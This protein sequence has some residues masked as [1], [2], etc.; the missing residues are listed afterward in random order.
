MNLARNDYWTMDLDDSGTTVDLTWTAATAGMTAD[1]FKE[2][3]ATFAGLAE[4]RDTPGLLVDVRQFGFQMTPDLGEWRVTDIVPRYNAAGVK[5]F[6]Y[7]FP[8]GAETPPESQYPGEDF[9]TG[10]FTSTGDA[11]AWLAG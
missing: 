4:E 2:A 7:V 3:L 9:Q 6:A 10:Y 11:R 1:D 5:R 8:T